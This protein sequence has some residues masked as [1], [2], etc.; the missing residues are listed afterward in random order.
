M[1]FGLTLI[2][3]VNMISAANVTTDHTQPK[4]TAVN[5]VFNTIITHSKPIILTFSETIKAGS[6]WI[7]LK[8]DKNNI[9]IKKPVNIAYP[10]FGRINNQLQH[11]S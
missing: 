3:N 8:D 1:L 9:P 7:E 2:L 11:I 6:L 4:I 10:R 5:P